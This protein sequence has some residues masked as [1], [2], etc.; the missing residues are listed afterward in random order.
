MKLNKMFKNLIN[1]ISA[2]LLILIGCAIY[3]SVENK[4]IGS[5]LFSIALF[6]IC[7]KKYSLF[8]GKVG[9]LY[10]AKIALGEVLFTLLGN[11]IG[12]LIFG[13]IIKIGLPSLKEVSLILINIKM[14]K[15]VSTRRLF[16]LFGIQILICR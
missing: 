8:T 2:G 1:G 15:D 13:S 12:L 9:Y 16:L 3:L 7:Y 6:T 14:I 5:L 11:I 4:I 10:R